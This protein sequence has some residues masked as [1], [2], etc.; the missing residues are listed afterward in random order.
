MSKRQLAS[1]EAS[2]DE[3]SSRAAE[4]PLEIETK[5]A[6]AKG[7]RALI[8]E[9]E[10]N[11]ISEAASAAEDLIESVEKALD[12]LPDIKHGRTPK[13]VQS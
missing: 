4:L 1:T 3:Q 11:A 9:V 13:E 12:E 6:Q 10:D 8:A 7:V 5:L 2:A